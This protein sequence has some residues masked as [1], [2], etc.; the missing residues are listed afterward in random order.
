MSEKLPEIIQL[1]PYNP[2]SVISKEYPRQFLNL[3]QFAYF[4]DDGDRIICYGAITSTFYGKQAELIRD[5]LLA[6]VQDEDIED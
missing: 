3:S 6:Q 2:A 5:L 1:P 4:E